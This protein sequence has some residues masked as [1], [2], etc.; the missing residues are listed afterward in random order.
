VLAQE[1]QK[2]VPEAVVR[3]SDG[4]LRV[5]YDK[6]PIKFQTYDN[7]LKSHPARFPSIVQAQ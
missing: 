6:I 2:V 3:G 1:V 5:L 4:Y 7:W